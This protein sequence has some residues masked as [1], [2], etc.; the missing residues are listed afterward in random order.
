MS[1]QM[2]LFTL[3][4]LT[5]PALI[6]AGAIWG[7]VWALAGLIYLTGVTASLD[8][9]VARV[10]PEAEAG[11]EFPNANALSVALALAHFA[12]LAL[13]VAALAG[14]T[15]LVT[16]EKLSVYGATGLFMGQISNSNA[17]ELIH[18]P[19]RALH[20]LGMWV[21]ISMLFGHHTSAH[22]LIHHRHAATRADPNTARRGESLYRFAARAWRG[23]FRLGLA[24]ES[25]RLQQTGR[26]RWRHPYVT[27]IGGA[28]LIVVLAALIGGARGVA[29]LLAIA[30][31]AQAQLMMSDYVQHYGLMRR[32]DPA[33]GK[34][35]PIGVRHSWNA[36][37]WFSSALMLNAPRHSDHHAHPSLPYPALT[38]P[39]PCTAPTLPRSLPVMA[40][41]ALYPRLWRRVMNPRADAW[42]NV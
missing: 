1:P 42:S 41:V 5:A 23:S 17:H 25:R 8:Q 32:D 29:A 7:G 36:P 38:L 11:A 31:F 37:H 6:A 4:T 35:E 19:R 9:F 12:V 22:P 21:Y 16:W 40:C 10:I 15:G 2:R 18:R 34:P 27:Y 30:A 3:T 24:A 14:R 39:D 28:V 13:V 20:R 26:A 33:T